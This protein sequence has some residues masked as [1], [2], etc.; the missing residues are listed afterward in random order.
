[1]RDQDYKINVYHLTI[2]QS[3]K[4]KNYNGSVALSTWVACDTWICFVYDLAV[5]LTWRHIQTQLV[6]N[7]GRKKWL[8]APRL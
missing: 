1:M 2:P 4:Y 7:T 8:L 5:V 3:E 6:S